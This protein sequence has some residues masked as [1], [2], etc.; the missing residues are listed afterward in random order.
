MP[1]RRILSA[2]AL[3]VLMT[4]AS[5]HAT[6]PGQNGKIAFTSS[7]GI[8]VIN[9]D[10]TG[11]AT[12]ASGGNFGPAYSS[13]GQK[14]AF[15]SNR[16]GNAEIYVMNADGTGQTRITNDPRADSQPSWSP[17]SS[18]IVFT[19]DS[20]IWSMRSDGTDQI[21]L[22]TGPGFENSPV[23]SPGGEEIAYSDQYQTVRLMKPDG[24][25]IQSLDYGLSPS[26]SP[27][28]REVWAGYDWNDDVEEVMY[29]YLWWMS[30]RGGGGGNYFEVYGHVDEPVVSP[31][32]TQFLTTAQPGY[33]TGISITTRGGVTHA[34]PANGRDPDWQPLPVNTPS[35]FARPRGATPI[36][37]PLVPAFFDCRSPNSTHG[38]PLAYGSCRSPS[39]RSSI[40][41]LG[42]PDANGKP[43]NSVG[44]VQF[45][46]HTG[47]P[48]GADT[49][50]VLISFS[51]TSVYNWADM[52]DY[53]GDVEVRT[54]LQITDKQAGVAATGVDFP[55]SFT[56]ACTATA[57]ADTGGSCALQTTADAIRPGLVPEGQRS[58]WELGK[59]VVLDSGFDGDIATPGGNT[60]F[61]TQ[62]VFIP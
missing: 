36:Y 45:V 48:G 52:T 4:P 56:A 16:D 3:V 59:T 53:G 18:R 57:A 7:G 25:E 15:A 5:A 28:A 32:N 17:D 20:D 6:F 35:A 10:G 46:V 61:A 39:L 19:R 42:T 29:E 30:I 58:V 40:L 21:G 12:L 34:L 38:A 62:G 14:I 47:T 41:T 50:D 37:V 44:F 54:N 9:P 55:L 60:P 31:D 27:D 11:L 51:L 2:V 13:D 43:A 8:S 24:S 1:A 22:V 49:S 23:W 26:W 33:G